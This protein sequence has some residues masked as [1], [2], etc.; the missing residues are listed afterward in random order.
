MMSPTSKMIANVHE[1]TSING[2]HKHLRHPSLR[3]IQ[4]LVK[5]FSFP[6][7]KENF[8]SQLC[9]SCTI[10]K[11]HQQHFHTNSLQ[12]HAPLELI[13]IDVWGPAHYTRI[14]GSH[15]YLILVYHFTK[16]MWFYPMATKSEVSTIF[17]HF[18]KLVETHFQT[19]IKN[20]YSDNG[21]EFIALK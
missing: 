4:H 7:V 10:N 12:S 3:I 9:S 14:D 19:K 6:E 18:K 11:A 16:Y 1:R 13:Y 21:G 20:L 2:W 17:P 15:Y 8:F 5:N